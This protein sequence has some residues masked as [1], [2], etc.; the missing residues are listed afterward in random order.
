VKKRIVPDSTLN[1]IKPTGRVPN[2]KPTIV[3]YPNSKGSFEEHVDFVLNEISNSSNAT[4]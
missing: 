3:R 2:E 4:G 1:P